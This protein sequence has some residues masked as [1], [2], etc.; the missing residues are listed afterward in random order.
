MGAKA[1]ATTTR[2]VRYILMDRVPASRSFISNSGMTYAGISK[3]KNANI[4]APN[5]IHANPISKGCIRDSPMVPRNKT[6]NCNSTMTSKTEER[7]DHTSA[8][9]TTDEDPDAR[10]KTK[11]RGDEPTHSP[12]KA[13][14][15]ARKSPTIHVAILSPGKVAVVPTNSEQ[16]GTSQN[17]KCCSFRQ[18]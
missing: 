15:A 9:G 2:H 13:A 14:P 18:K 17:A 6:H 11:Q 1:N 10:T 7:P 12:V 8:N 4:A 5:C 3:R 16:S